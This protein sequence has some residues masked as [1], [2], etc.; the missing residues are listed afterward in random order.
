M[1]RV[2]LFPNLDFIENPM[3]SLEIEVLGSIVEMNISLFLILF[4]FMW[5]RLI[6]SKK[7]SISSLVEKIPRDCN[8]FSFNLVAY[9]RNSLDVIE[10]SKYQQHYRMNV[11]TL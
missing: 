5:L 10:I 1:N 3:F 2:G 7:L 4:A 6:L 8:I 9:A 11:Y